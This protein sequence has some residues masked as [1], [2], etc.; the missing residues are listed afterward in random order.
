MGAGG[1]GGV[2]P[3]AVAGRARLAAR[4][5]MRILLESFMGRVLTR[6]GNS[7]NKEAPRCARGLVP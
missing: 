3:S 6:K 2:R 4:A 1:A 5:R 7:V